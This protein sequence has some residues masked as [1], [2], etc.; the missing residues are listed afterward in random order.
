M[1]DSF[2]QI[3]RE[4]INYYR[5]RAAEYDEWFYRKGRFDR[6]A[7]LNQR[8]FAEVDSVVAALDALKFVG[9]ILEL[10]PGTGIWTERLVK[11]ATSI[12]AVD[13]SSE[14]VE[15]NKSKV[16]SPKVNYVLAD[17][18]TWEPDRAYD[19]IFFGFWLSHVPEE[20]LSAFLA[21]T[22]RALRPGG[23]LFFVDSLRSETSTAVNHQ[24]PEE[25]NQIMTRKLN[26]GREFQIIKNFYAP[27]VLMPKFAA[28]GLDINVQETPNYFLY[29][30]GTKISG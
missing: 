6:G 25:G 24:L 9:D 20:Q 3:L 29:G 12:T 10:A 15:I 22:Y 2:D 23:K 16:Q 28:L 11:V 5:A 18:F 17:L 21:K 8:W 26:D 30:A 4:Q 14:M 13:A 7:E 1:S 19:G 27:N